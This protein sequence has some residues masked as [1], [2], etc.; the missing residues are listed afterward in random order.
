[1]E[2]AISIFRKLPETKSQIKKYSQLI[3]ESVL[4][5]EVDPLDFAAQVSALEQLFKNLKAD[6]LIKDVVLQEAEKY[7]KSFEKGNAKFQIKEMGVRFDYSNCEDVEW[8][9]ICSEVNKWTEKKKSRENFLRG[10]E[11]NAEVY[12]SDGT[13]LKPP[14]KTSTT[15]V[16][17]ILK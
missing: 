2:S 11:P 3:R 17:V 12:G 15:S 4:N 6:H 8:E 7:G 1:M 16:A 13:Q 9:T 5:G 10:I 14:V